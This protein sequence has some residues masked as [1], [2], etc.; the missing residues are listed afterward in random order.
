MKYTY[1]YLS[2]YINNFS[3][4]AEQLHILTE[5]YY[6]APLYARLIVGRMIGERS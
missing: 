2:E 6:L 5:L 3:T 4:T 1:E